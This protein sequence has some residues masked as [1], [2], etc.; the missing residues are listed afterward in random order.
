MSEQDVSA[1][2][3][4]PKPV[5]EADQ[6]EPEQVEAKQ[7]QDEDSQPPKP[8][9]E[10]PED[11]GEKSEAA[12]RRE[13]RKASME[14]LKANETEA[15]KRLERI[16][17]A[18]TAEAEPSRDDF[19]DPDDYT[20]AKA[21]WFGQQSY[22]KREQG[23]AQAELDAIAQMRTAETEAAWQEQ[24][25]AA[26]STYPDWDKVV[27]DPTVPIA[28]HVANLIKTSDMGA[29]V[30]YH[31]AANRADA[32]RLSS[33]HP[34]DAAREMGRLEATLTAPKPKTQ[35]AAPPPITPVSGRAQPARDPSKMSY[36][37]YKKWRNGG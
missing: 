11:E 23:A 9:G 6:V 25:A 21:A 18:A 3:A 12:K 30:A 16:K 26:R 2:E 17:Q 24:V 33:L 5:T 1:L 35:T 32:A 20:A 27:N 37:D 8:E 22:V 36:A 31:L 15:L 10:T 29:E 14:R 7:G 4:D 28:P 34:V 19:P 13:R